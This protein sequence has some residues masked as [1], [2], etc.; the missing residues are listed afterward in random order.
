VKRCSAA[1]ILLAASAPGVRA[2][3]S[4]DLAATVTIDLGDSAN[5]RRR[6]DPRD[7]LG[8]G[9]DGAV[10][11]TTDRIFTPGNVAAMRAAGLQSLTYR[12]RT[13]LGVEAWHW[14]PAGRWSDPAHAQGYWVSSARPGPPIGT[15]FGYRLPRRGD[16][17]DNANDTDYSR[18]TDGDP[19]SYWK[20]N[21]YLDPT[22][23][24]DGRRHRQWLVL[25]LDAPRPIDAIRIAWGEPYARR[26]RVQYWSSDDQ[27]A[28]GAHWSDFPHGAVR[29]GRGG[30]GIL[31]L[32]DRPVEARYVRVLLEQGSHTAVAGAKDWRD[33]A[34]FAVREIGLGQLGPD[35]ALTDYVRHAASHDAQTFAHVSSTDP[36][37]RASDR[38]DRM[39]QPGLDRVFASGLANGRP[40]LLAASLLF[41]VPEDVA[42]QLRY[43]RRRGYPFRQVELGE[44]PDGQYGEAEDYGALYLAFVDRLRRANPGV[45]FG[46]PSAQDADTATWMNADTDHSWNSHFLRYLADRHRL[47]DLGFYSFEF[48]PFDDLCGDIPARLIRQD[49][50][51]HDLMTRL[52]AEGVPR[53]IPWIMAEYGF[54]A[55]SGR[56]MAQMSSALLMANV[57]GQFLSEGG[58]AA[59]LYGYE[60][61]VPINQHQPCAGYGNM[62]LHMA[63]AGG[64]AAMP[65]PTFQAARMI[66]RAWLMAQGGP[67]TILPSVVSGA[68]EEMLRSYAVRRPDGRIGVL[69]INRDPLHSFNVDV[70]AR[71]TAGRVAALTGPAHRWRYG[72]AQY[73]WIDQG[74]ASHPSRSQPPVEDTLDAGAVVTSLPPQSL[75]VIVR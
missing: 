17:V 71:D 72:P 10:A 22:F 16:T 47:G 20:S 24:R 64:A 48:Y 63:D 11:G 29:D 5:G 38:D 8:A 60:P 1:L 13:E 41:A 55:Y 65:M 21:P 35:G 15:S 39:E 26:Y 6:F 18:L 53:T 14:N 43:L 2:Q 56:A 62:M 61:N 30:E 45:A 49:H 52:A 40:M 19:A 36:W 27:F 32:A 51:L 74:A 67:H 31:R 58:S 23:L 42:A 7:A 33:R 50:I 57:V 66:T 37:H 3:S 25:R 75:T 4:G 9:I 34:G 69:L 54:S 46:G 59:Y 28:R 12:L 44:E 73:E 70:L 68:Q